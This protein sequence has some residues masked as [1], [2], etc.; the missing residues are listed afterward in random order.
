MSK[1]VNVQ[2]FKN[3]NGC[4]LK[5][6]VY[7]PLSEFDDSAF[8][9]SLSNVKKQGSRSSYLAAYAALKALDDS[10]IDEPDADTRVYVGNSAPNTDAVIDALDNS[11]KGK[12]PNVMSVPSAMY[13]SA[14]SWV[15]MILQVHGASRVVSTACSSGTDSIGMAYEDVAM[16]KIDMAV[17]GGAEYMLDPDLLILKGFEGLKTISKTDDGS[18]YSFSSESSGFLYS[19]GGAAMLIIEE[20]E[21]AVKRNA[22]IYA[23][24]T[25]YNSCSDAYSII[26]MPEDGKNSTE[27]LLELIK[28]KKVDYYNAHSTCTKLNESVEASI[29]KKCFG[30][31]EDQPL[32]NSTKS[33]IGHTISASGAIEAVICADSIANGKIHGTVCKT[34]MDDLN[35]AVD[36]QY[37]DVNVA[38]SSSFGFGGHNSA[39]MFEKYNL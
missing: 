4:D 25:G 24:I 29:I 7:A 2:R 1:K 26:S 36:T 39:L 13:N 23:E 38:V 32:I 10:G 30:S 33:L 18:V 12:R 9:H 22:H 31:K 11:R 27:M 21:H 35:V 6:K 15:S 20:L 19:E 14:A 37:V 16:G 34:L 8:K 3:I 5:T 28:K 17:C